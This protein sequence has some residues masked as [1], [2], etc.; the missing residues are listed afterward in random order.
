MPFGKH[1]G[2]KLA[3]IPASYLIWAYDN[4]TLRDDLKAYISENMDALKQEAARAGK[5]S[6]K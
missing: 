2:T 6:R 3:N 5:E 4:L 1:K